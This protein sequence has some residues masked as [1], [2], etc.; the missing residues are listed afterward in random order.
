MALPDD[1]VVPIGHTLDWKGPTVP[2][3]LTPHVAAGARGRREAAG[4][5]EMFG[6]R[7]YKPT[8]P[9]LLIGPD[10]RTP[11]L[12]I[13]DGVTEVSELEDLAQ[14]A[15]DQQEDQI[16]AGG[17][18]MDFDKLREKH[19]Q[20]RTDQVDNGIR[21]AIA[22]RIAHHQQNPVTDPFRQPLRPQLGR[23]FSLGGIEPEEPK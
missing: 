1:F 17:R 21:D 5:S 16:A 9:I 11:I 12:L 3:L 14:A 10:G 2:R 8:A 22:A 23:T 4:L 15:I 20:V 19:G 6:S 13:G 18:G 7:S